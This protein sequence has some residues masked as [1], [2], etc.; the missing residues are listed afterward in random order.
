MEGMVVLFLYCHIKILPCDI[1]ILAC[2]NFLKT[3]TRIYNL[4]SHI[5]DIFLRR[6]NLYNQR[7]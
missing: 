3:T 6:T 5:Q 7:F 2:L 4:I 1:K